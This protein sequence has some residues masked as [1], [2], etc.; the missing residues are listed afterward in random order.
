MQATHGQDLVIVLGELDTVNPS[1]QLFEVRL[2][3][4]WLRCLTQNLQQIIVTN[5]IEARKGRS[6]LLQIERE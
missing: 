4:R 1:K 5:E 3:D 6:L 2:D